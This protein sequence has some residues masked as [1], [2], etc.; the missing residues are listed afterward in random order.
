MI[1]IKKILFNESQSNSTAIQNRLDLS[2]DW[3]TEMG[4]DENNKAVIYK[5]NKTKKACLNGI[6]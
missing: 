3:A 4:T 1:I 6:L 5:F 2:I